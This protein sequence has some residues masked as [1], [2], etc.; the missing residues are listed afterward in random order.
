M[1]Y[2]LNVDKPTGTATLHR[3]DSPLPRCQPQ[4][5]PIRYGYWRRFI[6]TPAAKAHSTAMGLVFALCRKCDD[7]GSEVNDA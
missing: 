1:S 7:E 4:E 2:W 6:T 3:D 5:K